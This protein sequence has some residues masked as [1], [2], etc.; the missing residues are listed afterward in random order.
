M[1][2]VSTDGTE[3]DWRIA[4]LNKF[5]ALNLSQDKTVMKLL[6]TLTKIRSG[7]HWGPNVVPSRTSEEAQF[8]VIRSQIRMSS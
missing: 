4:S 7:E 3:R 1:P 6:S 2:G 8:Q 5:H